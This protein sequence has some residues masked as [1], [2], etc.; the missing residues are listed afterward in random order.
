MLRRMLA[1]A[2][3]L[4]LVPSA[5]AQ[6]EPVATQEVTITA[7]DGTR[8][9]AT[10]YLP[11]GPGP[12][13]AV[14]LSH[15]FGNDRTEMER[16]GLRYAEK[17]WICLAWDARGFG[18]S[19]GLVGLN[20]PGEVQD[21]LGLVSWLAQRPDVL[22]DAPGDPRVAMRGGS[23]GGA[24]QLLAAAQ[25][26]RLDALVPLITWNDLVHSLAPA[27]VPKIAWI[28]A[29]FAVGNTGGHGIGGQNPNLGGLDPAIFR[30]YATTMAQGRFDAD[31]KTYLTA[32]SVAP[33][34]DRVQTPTYLVQGWRD[35]LF[36]PTEAARTWST[37]TE[38][39]VPAKLLFYEGGH[40]YD[41]LRPEVFDPRETRIDAWLAFWLAG[42]G[43]PKEIFAAPIEYV[44]RALDEF[45]PERSWPPA[46]IQDLT[47]FLAG[48]G[49]TG[50]GALSP[51]RPDAA[52]KLEA[53]A[54][55][56]S[57]SSSIPV[58]QGEAD[59]PAVDPVGSTIT[60][61]SLPFP[62]A[63]RVAGPPR[64]LLHAAATSPEVALFAKLYDVA[65]DGTATLVDRQASVLRTNASSDP[66][67]VEA[68]PVTLEL[69]PTGFTWEK[70]HQL[71][72]TI[73]TSDATYA[74]N[75]VPARIAIFHGPTTPSQLTLPLVPPRN[76]SAPPTIGEATRALQGDVALIRVAVADDQG[77]AGAYL[78]W[79]EGG[80]PRAATATDWTD[81]VTFEAPAHMTG[82][83]TLV[84][85]DAAGNTATSTF[86]FEE[87]PDSAGER[88]PSADV[89]LVVVAL[90]FSVFAPR[91]KG[92]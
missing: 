82:P 42:L 7:P 52:T 68:H 33:V 47:L 6:D 76:D 61:T 84:V 50:V 74:G 9:A 1:L 89:S 28:Q 40:G 75:R 49:V 38:N 80:R 18:E 78:A 51:E 27:D 53:A 15:G 59:P 73:A 66:G 32:R 77:V 92:R 12:Y 81:G 31:A 37:L 62:T 91:R 46:D 85:A 45:Q 43:E 22:L 56:Q 41:D 35:T 83:F 79:N 71:R 19:E 16:Y 48:D 14:L 65:P 3:L 20:G 69:V 57:S 58:V 13:P 11:G 60:Y 17:G 21:V 10:L 29:L 39:G 54:P 63:Q 4:L 5:E 55:A 8:L 70:D 90:A 88:T 67:L 87:A 86:S 72:L 30:H 2:V 23:Y 44:A 64:L 34:L 36:T 26:P 25:D 24:I